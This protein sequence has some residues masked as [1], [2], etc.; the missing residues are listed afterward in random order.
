LLFAF[1]TA[2]LMA[3]L[4]VIAQPQQKVYRVGIL[5]PSNP[6]SIGPLIDA[7]TQRLG[8]LGYV[9]GKNISIERRF[10]EGE[11]DRLPALA[12]DLVQQKMDVIFAPNTI[13]VQAAKQVTGTIPIV[14]ASVDDPVGIGF[15][16]SLGRPGGNITGISAIQQELS[17]KR[18]QLLREAFPKL[19]RLVVLTSSSESVSKF[20]FSIIE[21]A[22]SGSTLTFAARV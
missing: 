14:F 15:V 22:A 6:A 1:V 8:E 20:Q 18:V 4:T 17:A 3:P 5:S 2:A 9:E 11:L 19:S 7:F 10:A 12:A 21:N 16:A 13:A